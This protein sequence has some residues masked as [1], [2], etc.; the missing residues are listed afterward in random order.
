M[1]AK[2]P[3]FLLTV[4]LLFCLGFTVMNLERTTVVANWSLRRCELPIMVASGFFKPDSDPRSKTDF[5][6]DN[7][8]F[9]MK[10]VIDNFLDLLMKPIN[11]LFGQ[12]LDVASSAMGALS[13]VRQIAQ[14]LY[15]AFM[16]YLGQYFKKFNVAIFEM[17]RIVQYI[18]MAVNRASA[19]AIS[20][21]YSGLSLFRGMINS[22]QVVIRV[23][24]I[25]CGIMLAIIIILWF[26]LFPV[27]PIILGTLAA[28][29]AVVMAMAGILG[30]QLQ[31]DAES[32]KSGFCFA[33]GS[34]IVT[35]NAEGKQECVP[36]E[37]IV[38][39]QSLGSNAGT[40]TAIIKMDGSGIPMYNLEGI[41]VSESHL[42]KGINGIWTSVGE[43]PRAVKTAF[44][45]PILYCFNTTS[46]N[47]P[48]Q[49]TNDVILFRDW[50]EIGNEDETGQYQWNEMV[51]TMLNETHYE[52]DWRG[53]CKTDWK[54]DVKA[55]CE[56]AL[57]AKDILVKTMRGF[58]PIRSIRLLQEDVV[59]RNGKPQKVRG[60]VYGTVENATD[61]R[62]WI[63][64][65]YEFENAQWRKKP[66][67]V[68]HGSSIIEGMSLITESGEFVIWDETQQKERF[69]RDFT[70]VGY[71]TIHE[72]YAFVEA[73]LRIR[74]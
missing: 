57:M 54:K 27:I 22:I 21:I 26:I 62:K 63:S 20:T 66:S 58:V 74:E 34:K 38:L 30:S 53:A 70:E 37:R 71:D 12:H 45:S 18:R 5:A 16:D 3:F 49:G 24:L 55:E 61:N 1:E 14:K 23:V 36:V 69:I 15:T 28:V 47:V 43:D 46:N 39:G 52:G 6:A 65:C 67:S 10:K 4:F 11:A 51:S 60:L 40:I 2:W 17:S 9:C 8:E 25:I 72:T 31:S 41:Y 68:L 56:V 42:V 13:G 29:I 50:E 48:I 64:E 33:E 44:T 35:I 7:F 32:K 59:D 73:R 19:I